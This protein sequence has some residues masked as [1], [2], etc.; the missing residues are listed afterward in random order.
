MSPFELYLALT[1]LCMKQVLGSEVCPL[2]NYTWLDTPLSSRMYSFYVEEC[3]LLKYTWLDT[4]LQVEG[5]YGCGM[6]L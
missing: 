1:H 5:F 2:L 3:P 6:S 4:P